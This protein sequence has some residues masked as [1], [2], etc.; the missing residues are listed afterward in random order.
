MDSG[1]LSDAAVERRIASR[2]KALRGERGWSLEALAKR[3]GISRATLSRLENAEVSP[4]TAVL[5][6]L[7]AVFGLT[8]SRLMLQVEEGFPALLRPAEQPLWHDPSAGFTRRSLSPPAQPLAGEVLECSL[9]AGASIS[10]EAPPRPGLEHH[11]ALREGRLR[12]T[13]DGETY[14]LSA[15]D[16]LRYRLFASSRFETPPDSGARYLLFL[17]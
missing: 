16:C 3:S 13:L 12:L 2:L 7:C 9:D 1:I 6:K 8:L 15:G 10:Y 17:V 5:G 14:D 11:L 4:T